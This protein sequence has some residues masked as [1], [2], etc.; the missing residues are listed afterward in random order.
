VIYTY[1]AALVKSR[2]AAAGFR[3]IVIVPPGV[4]P[5]VRD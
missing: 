2:P 5:P 4:S 3:D 1:M